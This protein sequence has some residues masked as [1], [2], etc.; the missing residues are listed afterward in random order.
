[1]KTQKGTCG[2]AS[3][4]LDWSVGS[5]VPIRSTNMVRKK[6]C[7][8]AR[9]RRLIEKIERGTYGWECGAMTWCVFATA[10][11]T[12]FSGRMDF[13]TAPFFQY[14]LTMRGAF[15]QGRSGED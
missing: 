10:I 12:R 1:M 2:S 9:S 8:T 3:G 4:E 6:V 14:F 11:L 15:G 7:R 5:E 13:R